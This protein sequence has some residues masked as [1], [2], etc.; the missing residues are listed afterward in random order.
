MTSPNTSTNSDDR[1]WAEEE[2]LGFPDFPVLGGGGM[3]GGIAGLDAG[4]RQT[5]HGP[6]TQR[7]GK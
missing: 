1:Q 4:W 3:T 2:A 7:T 6:A 5:D